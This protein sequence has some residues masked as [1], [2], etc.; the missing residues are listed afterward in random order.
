MAT[1]PTSI[2][3][4]IIPAD[5]T[6]FRYETL[7]TVKEEIK[8]MTHASDSSEFE[9]LCL[10]RLNERSEDSYEVVHS[11]GT[12]RQP[13]ISLL[14]DTRKKH[15]SPTAWE[16]RSVVGT[17][18]YHVFFTAHLGADLPTNKNLDDSVSGDAFVLKLSDIWDENGLAFYVDMEPDEIKSLKEL[19][20][21][22]NTVLRMEQTRLSYE[23]D[24]ILFGT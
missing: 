6:D 12:P 19:P 23:C 18:E 20:L 17:S 21:S 9:R 8:P 5:G 1:A 16:K 4:L 14:P 24:K 22:P 10:I 11:D 13:K 2:K 15:W 3:V 7:G